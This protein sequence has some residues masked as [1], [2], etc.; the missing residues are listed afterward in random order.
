MAEIYASEIQ[1]VEV[2]TDHVVG[3]VATKELWA[4]AP[5]AS[6]RDLFGSV[7]GRMDRRSIDRST[8]AI[9]TGATQNEA[10]RSSGIDEIN[11][12]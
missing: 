2:T 6:H 5:R 8:K 9:R 12:A 3:G 4:V 7:A 11:K 10:R 1:L